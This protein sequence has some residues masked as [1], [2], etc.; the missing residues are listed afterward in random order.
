MDGDGAIRIGNQTARGAGQMFEPFEYAVQ[1]GFDAFEW[2]SDRQGGQGFDFS[3]LDDAACRR[4]KQRAKAEDIRYSVHAPLAARPMTPQ[5][6]TL[7]KTAMDFARSI[8]AA[9][10]VVHMDEQAAAGHYAQ[11]LKSILARRRGGS[12]TLAVENVPSTG[13]EVFNQLFE[14]VAKLACRNRVGMCFD[15]GHANLYWQTRNDYLAYMDGL[16]EHVPMIHAHVHENAGDADSHLPLFTGPAGEDSRGVQAWVSRILER[17]FQGLMIMEQWPD[18][19]AL[20]CQARD[21][22]RRLI[23]KASGPMR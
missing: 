15:L 16:G 8:G 10:V 22:L 18:P 5:G 13:P 12:V 11:A 4:L 20:L 1:C 3:Q 23:S 17:G 7:V 9:V 14:A 2:F 6:Q 19:P 21:R